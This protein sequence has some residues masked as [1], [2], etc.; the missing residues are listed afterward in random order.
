MGPVVDRKSQVGVKAYGQISMR[1]YKPAQAQQSPTKSPSVWSRCR[2]H[3]PKFVSVL[4]TEEEPAAMVLEDE[5]D[6]VFEPQITVSNFSLRISSYI[7][8]FLIGFLRLRN[9]LLQGLYLLHMHQNW[10]IVVC[11]RRKMWRLHMENSTVPWQEV[12]EQTVP[13][14]WRFMTWD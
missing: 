8:F 6:S 10:R 9:H 1:I 2:I 4:P 3:K 13:S 11:F 14:S 7:F 12:R 5:H